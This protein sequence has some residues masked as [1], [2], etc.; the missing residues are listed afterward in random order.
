MKASIRNI[1]LLDIDELSEFMIS[2]NEEKYRAKQIY[3]WIWKKNIN[4][5]HEIKNIP[6]EL[7]DKLESNFCIE[8][9]FLQEKQISNDNTIKV[10]FKTPKHELIESVIIPKQ[11]RST[12]CIS[13]QTGCA[14]NCSFCATGKLSNPRNLNKSEIVDQILKLNE[15]SIELYNQKLTNIVFMGMGEPLLNYN[16]L[17]KSISLI[18]SAYGL[19]FSPSR[20]TISTAGI[21]KTIIKMA[22]E[23]VKFK[24][25]V[26][27]HSAKDKIRTLLMPVNK[28][29]N[30]K[31]LT[32]SLI[33]FNKKTDQRITFEYL[34]LNGINDSLNDAKELANFCKNFPSKINI[35]EYNSIPGSKYSKSSSQSQTEFVN[36][37]KSKNLI[38]KIRNSRG[39]DINAACGQLANTLKIKNS[40]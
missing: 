15:L 14:L 12:A 1:R 16:N 28:T 6:K 11:D 36:F 4:N 40:G 20:I 24:L 32:E 13:T 30:L 3:E 26:S 18:T 35:I 7:I 34:L 5:F 38:V 10:A 22:D 37:L 25:A 17:V 33:Y 27:L 2:I 8:K 19:G 31:N 39:H 21:S 9:L 23:K 29:Y